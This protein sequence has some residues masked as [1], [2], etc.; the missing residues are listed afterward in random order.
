M[1][2]DT[3]A[4]VTLRSIYVPDINY[5]DHT[6]KE[7]EME[8][9]TSHDPNKMSSNGWLMNYRFAGLKDYSSRYV[10]RIME[11]ARRTRFD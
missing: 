7:T 8:I 2:K 6:V 3:S 5:D 1:I 10:F 4:V 11:R 9:V